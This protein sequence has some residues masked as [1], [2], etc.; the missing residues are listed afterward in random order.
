MITSLIGRAATV[1]AVAAIALTGFGVAQ[2]DKAVDL[3]VEG[4]LTSMHVFGSTVADA[5]AKSCLLYT[6]RCV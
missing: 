3:T 4:Q 5:L 1:G 6:S 2:L